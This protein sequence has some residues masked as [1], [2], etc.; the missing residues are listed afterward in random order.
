MKAT[1]KF[2]LFTV[3]LLVLAILV[4]GNQQK[5]KWKGKVEKEEGI[6]VV[7]NPKQPMYGEDV[8]SLEEELS[9]G[10]KEGKEDDMFSQ[11]QHIAVSGNEKIYVLD[12][13]ESHIK[14]FDNDGKYL[15]TI[16]RPGQGPG[17]LNRPRSI[18]LNQN[19]LMVQELGR[20]FSF[21]SLGGKFLRNVSTKEIWALRSRI[22]S[23]SNIVITEGFLDPKNPCYLLKKFDSDMNLL[24]EIATSTAPDARKSFNPFMPIH[25]WLIDKDDNIV[26]GYPKEYEIQ[27]FNPDGKQIKK[28]TKEYEPVEITE[29]EK[30]EFQEG[31]PPQARM[32]YDFSKYHSAFQRFFL[33]DEGRIYVQTWEKIGDKEIY[34][35]DVFDNEGKYVARIPLRDTPYV[36]FRGKIYSMEEDE[37]GYQIVKRYRVDWK[38]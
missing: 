16:G 35:Y 26:Y 8:F 31:E 10:G 14:V 36:C 1:I 24:A 12:Y 18:S 29:E 25:Y 38:Y 17:E 34:N 13:K 23:K 4:S 5:Q 15:M 6:L 21:F 11:I 30:K 22:D 3:F 27:I 9:I 19:E 2:V 32:R 37:E 20:R 33:D 28:I 7:K